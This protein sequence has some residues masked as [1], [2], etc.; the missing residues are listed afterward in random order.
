AMNEFNRADVHAA[1][2]LR[3]QQQ[4]RRQSKFTADDQL[5]LI[6]SR[7]RPRRQICVCRPDVEI[8]NELL[9][10]SLNALDVE[11]DAASPRHSGLAVVKTQYRVLGKTRIQEK[12]TSMPVFR[13]MRDAEFFP[14][15]CGESGNVFAF[16]FDLPAQPASVDKPGERFDQFRLSVSLNAGYTNDFACANIQRD[17]SQMP[18]H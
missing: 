15:A 8:L 12:T 13:H 6:A 11:H 17:A 7:E 2:R 10:A 18:V 5:L 4:L 16:E 9:G 14:T 3:Y 1:R